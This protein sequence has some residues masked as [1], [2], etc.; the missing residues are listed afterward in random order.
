MRF[1][2]DFVSLS[3]I[4][5]PNDCA[6][7]DVVV[8]TS[9]TFMLIVWHTIDITTKGPWW[10]FHCTVQDNNNRKR[11]A[12]NIFH[13]PMYTKAFDSIITILHLS[14]YWDYNSNKSIVVVRQINPPL[15]AS[16]SLSYLLPYFFPI[17]LRW[18]SYYFRHCYEHNIE[19]L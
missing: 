8:L 9:I 5:W 15:N 7:Y 19:L 11:Y 2:S 1:L 4:A 3:H 13:W 12:W 17:L 18:Q 14:N 10:K 6:N 16:W